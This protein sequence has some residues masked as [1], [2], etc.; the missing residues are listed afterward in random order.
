MGLEK[1]D[2]RLAAQDTIAKRLT[3][4]KTGRLFFVPTNAILEGPMTTAQETPITRR[5]SSRAA[6]NSDAKP[7]SATRRSRGVRQPTESVLAD[8]D[9]MISAL[10]KENRELHRQIDKVSR[11]ALG[12]TSGTAERALRSIQR[13]I[14]SA[15]SGRT[16]TRRRRSVGA[17]P[18]SKTPRKITDPEVL[19]RRRQALAKA[20]AAR[21]AKQASAQP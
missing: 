18:V 21:A 17:A 5:R 14:S 8:L 13:R 7:S 10:I 20:R 9:R 16:T 19:E 12:A 3:F 1:D 15:V 2:S 6:R 11:Q 4:C